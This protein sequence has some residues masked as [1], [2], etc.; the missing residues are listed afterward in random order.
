M[1]DD[2]MQRLMDS[3]DTCPC[4]G[5]MMC[6]VCD[7]RMDA[8]AEIERLRDTV[9]DLRMHLEQDACEIERLHDT[10]DALAEQV[11]QLLGPL[12]TDADG[13]T[14]ERHQAVREGALRLWA[15]ARRG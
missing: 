13:S 2:I 1:S 4:N 6:R 8:V 9:Q 10:G 5:D 12:S 15:E 11:L 14:I 7:E 3:T